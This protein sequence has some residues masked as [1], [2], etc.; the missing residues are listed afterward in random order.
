M[1]GEYAKS[2]SKN[3]KR[4]R[5]EIGLT[6]VLFARKL[7]I[8]QASLNRLEPVSYT[9]LDVYK[10]QLKGRLLATS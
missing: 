1:S 4:I 6:Q 7:G 8:S 3:L 9:H 10:R 5:A 2:L